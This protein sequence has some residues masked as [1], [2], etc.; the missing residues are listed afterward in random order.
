MGSISD[1][2]ALV[3]LSDDLIIVCPTKLLG[4]PES[5]SA[6]TISLLINSAVDGFIRYS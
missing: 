6:R 5:A 2:E 1:I 3:S 4:F